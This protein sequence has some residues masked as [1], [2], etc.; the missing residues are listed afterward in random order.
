MSRNDEH[1]RHHHLPRYSSQESSRLSRACLPL[2][3]TQYL[4]RQRHMQ[5]PLGPGARAEAIDRR[6]QPSQYAGMRFRQRRA[7]HRSPPSSLLIFPRAIS[8]PTHMTA[9]RVELPGS[10]YCSARARSR[11]CNSGLQPRTSHETSLF[12]DTHERRH[13]QNGP[14]TSPHRDSLPGFSTVRQLAS[15]EGL[16]W[17]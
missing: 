3:L 5:L 6:S 14:L 10:A 2:L 12:I 13:V 8:A 1:D 11:G 4:H 15:F 17:I 9:Q 16:R 7:C